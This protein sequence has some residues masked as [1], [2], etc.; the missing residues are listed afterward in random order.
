MRTNRPDWTK[1]REEKKLRALAEIGEHLEVM[2]NTLGTSVNSARSKMVN[3]GIYNDYQLARIERLESD[4]KEAKDGF[5]KTKKRAVKSNPAV[6]GKLNPDG[7][8]DKKLKKSWSR[9]ESN[10]WT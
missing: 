4:L 6:S 2:G 1:E 8:D 5:V 3:L 7:I 10:G 9:A